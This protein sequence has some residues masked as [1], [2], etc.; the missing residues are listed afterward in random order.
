M[1]SVEKQELLLTQLLLMFQTAAMQNLG[2][3]KNPLS[4]TI[5]VDLQQAQISIDML[6]M[7]RSKMKGNLN[8]GEERMLTSV[9]HDLRMAYVDE[10]GKAPPQSG[11][12]NP[13][14]AAPETDSRP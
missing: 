10:Q 14:S 3:L 5:E 1:D 13:P 2:K 8:P 6:D 11:R 9:L 12:Q 4:G 7:I